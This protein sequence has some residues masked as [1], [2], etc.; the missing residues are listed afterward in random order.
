MKVYEQFTRACFLGLIPGLRPLQGR[1][2]CYLPKPSVR[3]VV[4]SPAWGSPQHVFL[5]ALCERTAIRHRLELFRWAQRR[6]GQLITQGWQPLPGQE[7]RHGGL[8]GSAGYVGR[9]RPL[10]GD[11]P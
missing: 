8:S 5:V 3:R 6:D 4:R 1:F 10:L 2:A 11:S 7:S 9:T